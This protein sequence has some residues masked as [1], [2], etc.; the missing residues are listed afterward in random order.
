MA[1]GLAAMNG[2]LLDAK[3]A[4]FDAPLQALDMQ[5]QFDAMQDKI[6]SGDTSKATIIQFLKTGFQRGYSLTG[7]T[8][9]ATVMLEDTIEALKSEMPGIAKEISR[10]GSEIG[11]FD[12]KQQAGQFLATKG[13]TYATLVKAALD[14]V[15]GL[16]GAFS[17][18]QIM[19]GMGKRIQEGGALGEAGL[20]DMVNMIL[21]ETNPKKAAIAAMTYLETGVLSVADPGRVSQGHSPAAGTVLPSNTRTY[22]SYA[23]TITINGVMAASNPEIQKL[24]TDLTDA[25][26]KKYQR[27]TQGSVLP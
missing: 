10:V 19:L 23:P 3:M 22:A 18:D 1:P 7:S 2:Q 5:N 25:Q 17:K 14:R 4:L 13:E 16:K 20:D 21:T 11:L 27:Q 9:K 15:P 12:K 6:A 24:V 26:L 8:A